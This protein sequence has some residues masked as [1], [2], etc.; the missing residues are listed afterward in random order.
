MK[1]NVTFFDSEFAAESTL[2]Y[3]VS[4]DF[5]FP[6]ARMQLTYRWVTFSVYVREPVKECGDGVN[7]LRVRA[8]L[9][10]L[11]ARR[12]YTS[13]SF[14]CLFEIKVSVKPSAV[15]ELPYAET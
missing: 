10:R 1:H 7:K 14:Q 5:N 11:V 12:T 4:K 6:S 13:F 8:S 9:L 3:F 2:L 15:M